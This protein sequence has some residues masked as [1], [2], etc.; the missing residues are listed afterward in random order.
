MC[1]C[2]GSLGEDARGANFREGGGIAPP[3]FFIVVISI[4][5]IKLIFGEGRGEVS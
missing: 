4:Y 5:F 2:L 3:D 1:V